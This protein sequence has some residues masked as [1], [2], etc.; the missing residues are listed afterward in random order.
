MKTFGIS[1]A[2]YLMQT[3][4]LKPLQ[5]KLI[6][7][8]IFKFVWNRHY[9]AS[10][11][12]ERIKREIMNK[13]IKHGGYGMLDVV[14]LDESLKLKALGRLKVTNH[15]LLTLIRNKCDLNK[16]FEPQCLTKI[17]PVIRK[18]VE[19]LRG[20]RNKIWRDKNLENST[21]VLVEVQQILLADIVSRV[22]R[23]SIPYF[24]ARR[25][26]R[27]KIVDLTPGELSEIT[28]FIDKDKL[29]L[30]RKAIAIPQLNRTMEIKTSI[31]I[32]DRLKDI[33]VCSSKEIRESRSDRSPI[34]NYKI[35]ASLSSKEA[36]TWGLKI[37]KLKSTKH[38]NILLRVAHGEVYTKEKLHRF[39]LSDSNLCPRCGQIETLTHKFIDCEYIRRIWT[40][41][42]LILSKLSPTYRSAGIE[43][44]TILGMSIGSTI[45]SLTITAELLL[46]ISYLKDS[47]NYLIHPKIFL[48]QC[49]KATA[50]NERKSAIGNEIKTLLE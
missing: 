38:K 30:I 46:R 8:L 20:D 28:R 24:M 9:L 40:Q 13:P 26:G 5:Y 14:A 16:F 2:I 29:V 12:P 49:L 3:L 10:K 17:E 7:N 25:R 4:E 37:S 21:P 27:L 11:A 42:N 47:Q 18:G 41:A 23:N 45:A 33:S 19:L 6:N 34:T 22:G 35:G 44:K 32:K 15:P 31:A 1:Q 39:N 48:N 36:L 50:T 43:S